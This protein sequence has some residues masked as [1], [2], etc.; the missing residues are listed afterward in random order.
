MSVAGMTVGI[1]QPYFLPYIG[2]W[3]LLAAVDRFVV[4]DDVKY[5]KKGWI[6]RNRFLRNGR[7]ALFTLPLKKG[8]DFLN[9]AD[10]TLADDFDPDTILNPF[11]E[12]Y[13]Q[14]PFFGEAFSVIETIVTEPAHNLFAYLYHSI[15]A[16]ATYLDIRT[17]LL[18]S[19]TIGIDHRLK[20][21]RRVLAICDAIG[22]TRYINSIGGRQ[23]YSVD[24]F[25]P[26][27]VELKFLQPRVVAYRQF[28]ERFVP[29][30]SIVDVMMFN[31]KEAVRA[32]LGEYDLV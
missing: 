21:D 23:L 19:S 12:A 28:G 31:S 26:R 14:A 9:I 8:S 13:R 24:A 25:A 3:Q 10:R 29:S 18:V 27:G 7:E 5:T 11:R 4:H 1:M 15:Q 16:I 30:L 17:P 6:N 32:M 2:Y 20:A 22:A